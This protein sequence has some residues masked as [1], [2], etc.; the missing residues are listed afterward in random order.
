[1]PKKP[2]YPAVHIEEVSIGVKTNDNRRKKII[3]NKFA[4]KIKPIY[5]WDDIVI[6]QDVKQNLKAII[7]HVSYK[8]KIYKDWRLDIKLSRS[9]GILVLFSGP[10]GTGKTMAA[11]IIANELKLDLYRIDLSSV[12][13][14]YIGETEKNLKKVFD[15]AEKSNAILFFDEADALFGKRS[16]IKDSHERYSNIKINYLL[17]KMEEYKGLCI[18][19]TNLRNALDRAFLRCIRFVIDFPIPD[20]DQRKAI[21]KKCF[22]PKIPNINVD[23]KFLAKQFKISGGDIR[24]ITVNATFLAAADNTKVE[25]KHIITSLKQEFIKIGKPC[26][27]SEFGPY[28]HMVK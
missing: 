26:L 5:S 25:M 10:P 16:E 1:M 9:T 14:K 15:E 7:K 17:Q 13:N 27:E 21:W 12:V 20:A 6:S 11:E 22:E 2:T 18:L 8:R 24:N 3:R 4:Q 19:A 23:F 28:Y